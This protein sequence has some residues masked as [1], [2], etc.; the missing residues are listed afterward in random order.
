MSLLELENGMLYVASGRRR[1]K[2][3]VLAH[4]HIR[5]GKNTTNGVNGFRYFWCADRTGWS[6]CRCGWR[7][8]WGVHYS[9]VP[10]VKIL[11]RVSR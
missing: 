1:P 5:H 9:K 7:P 8:D 10:R 4:N 3:W 2:G 11:Q 6:V